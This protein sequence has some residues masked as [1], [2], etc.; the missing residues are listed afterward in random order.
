MNHK[1][2]PLSPP[3]PSDVESVLTN[4]PKTQDG[5]L[6]KLFRVFAN[7]LRF[8]K[9]KGVVNLLDEE[10][11]L[12]LRQRELV[13][14]RVT[15]NLECEYEWSV[16]ATVFAKAAGLSQ[17][18]LMALKHESSHASC[19]T[20]EESTLLTCVDEICQYAT[21][22]EETYARFQQYWILEQQLEILALCGNYHTVS[23]VANTSRIEMEKGFSAFPLK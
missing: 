9:D 5:Y 10:S 19:W 23:F 1:L 13:I 12:T 20:E 3:Y 18:C 11:P 14:L 6:L 21:I 17:D 16:H 8:L 2:E 7:S 22:R 15:G 4:Y